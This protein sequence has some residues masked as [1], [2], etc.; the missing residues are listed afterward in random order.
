MTPE[1]P[2]SA[3][4]PGASTPRALKTTVV[5]ATELPW[6]RAV[7][8]YCIS[9][10]V[11]LI[12]GSLRYTWHYQPELTAPESGPFIFA[13]WHNRSSVAPAMFQDFLERRGE[14]RTLA[15][16]VSL[17]RDGAIMTRVLEHFGLQV[18]RGSSSRRG[19]QALLELVTL[20]ERG[21]DLAISPDGPRG[22]CYV[23][24][25]GT[26]KLA[27]ITGLPIVPVSYRLG[28]K[29]RLKSWDRHMIPLPLSTVDV[30]CGELLRVPRDASDAQL[31]ELRLELQRRM[32][33]ITEE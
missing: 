25:P 23:V 28:W 30:R 15:V 18:V 21:C 6:G 14:R 33:A 24:Q 3:A 5:A 16:M 11:R 1:P 4:S 22:P 29:I 26:I 31:E 8:A 19:G 10:L 2:F 9:L 12:T 27:Q 13:I 17:S 32:L 7:I 20:A